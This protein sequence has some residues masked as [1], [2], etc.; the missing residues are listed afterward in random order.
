MINITINADRSVTKSSDRIGMEL[1]NLVESLVISFPSTY[2][3]YTG[4]LEFRKPDNTIYLSEGF[5]LTTSPYTFA[6]PATL[7][8]VI[9]TLK[10]QF[11]AQHSD[12]RIW[13]SEEWEQTI[14]SSINAAEA[15]PEIDPNFL[16]DLNDVIADAEQAIS[17]A[18]TATTNA[19]EATELATTAAGL[20]D[21]ARGLTETATANAITATNNAV[22]ATGN[23]NDAIDTID[24][25][26]SDRARKYSAVYPPNDLPGLIMDETSDNTT[27]LTDIIDYVASVGGGVILLPNITIKCNLV[28]DKSNITL[29]GQSGTMTSTTLG[30][31]VLSPYNEA[32]D[33]VFIGNES[34]YQRNVSLQNLTIKGNR[35][36][37]S[38]SGLVI[39]GVYNVV[40]YRV[41]VTYFNKNCIYLTSATK[42][43]S[44]I[45]FVCCYVSYAND[46]L[47]KMVYGATWT[48][49]ISWTSLKG[50][51][52]PT[53]Q[54][55]YLDGVD[56]SAT[57]V[58]FDYSTGGAVTLVGADKIE[59]INIVFDGDAPATVAD[60]IYLGSPSNIYWEFRKGIVSFDPTSTVKFSDD[61]VLPLTTMNSIDIQAFFTNPHLYAPT[62]S[63][64][65]NFSNNALKRIT[66]EAS[67][68]Y[69]DIINTMAS[70]IIRLQS[71][72][73]VFQKGTAGTYNTLSIKN[74]SGSV[75]IDNNAGKCDITPV[76]TNRLWV[77]GGGLTVV[78]G[79][80]VTGAGNT[81]YMDSAFDG[82]ILRMANNRI[83]VDTA[84]R[85]RVK[86][87]IPSSATDGTVIGFE[88]LT[89]IASTPVYVGQE[90]LVG[91]LWYKAIG[92]S[93]TAD[94][95][96]V[97]SHAV[98]LTNKTGANTLAG[99]I[100]DTSTTTDN[101]FNLSA[102]N[103]DM[104]IGIVATSGIAD[105]SSAVLIE[106]G[107]ADVLFKDGV[108][109]TRGYI[110]YCSDTAGR[111]DQSATIPAAATHDRE[112]G[113]VL[114][115]KASGTNV[116][117]K[118]ILHFR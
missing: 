100:A 25:K 115:T 79:V 74:D 15:I 105:G 38:A 32:V 95:K 65:I 42:P 96:P 46:Y 8:D 76:G 50:Q 60:V 22:T 108:A 85:I 71:E 5:A 53:G 69:L 34:V 40:C 80:S 116:T 52:Q 61:V 88:Y 66:A 72:N 14:T 1:E 36:T 58:Y 28:I 18:E 103:S 112:I 67:S 13:K 19:D 110:A 27:I 48:T 26:L 2:S 78:G 83:W 23:A 117:A 97:S 109:P 90:A 111:A 35:T 89:S 82:S 101:A 81:L 44:H 31:T 99:T 87:G 56:F 94:W 47:I 70:S 9:G 16:Q 4:Y 104:P 17:D 24:E 57:N 43:T 84:N 113:H 68:T 41:N 77:Y 63:G 54:C 37:G 98:A 91:S 49:S 107:I 20:A 55:L 92:T 11:R 51:A 33:C 3:T 75:I 39:S 102:V 64:N 118:C 106:G 93:S 12:G 30:G 59:G 10:V 86:N 62:V 21:T 29:E 45:E 7:L 73:V 114:E 6:I